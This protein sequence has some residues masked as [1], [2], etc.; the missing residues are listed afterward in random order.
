MAAAND[1]TTITFRDIFPGEQCTHHVPTC[2][3]HSAL[4]GRVMR[5]PCA[6]VCVYMCRSL[7]C[8]G[9]RLREHAVFL[10]PVCAPTCSGAVS[11]LWVMSPPPH[12]QLEHLPSLVSKQ[13][14]GVELIIVSHKLLDACTSCTCTYL[15]VRTSTNI[16]I[17]HRF[18]YM[19]T[20]YMYYNICNVHIK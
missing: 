17:M 9:N 16:P 6:H 13:L 20:I 7:S 18:M 12:S 5:P 14:A 11:M 3:R 4:L 2:N 1:Q 19:Y 10:A 15:H 8:M